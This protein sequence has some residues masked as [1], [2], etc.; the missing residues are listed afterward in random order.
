M[1]WNRKLPALISAPWPAGSF[2]RV[3]GTMPGEHVVEREGVKATDRVEQHD[4]NGI[5]RTKSD[6]FL[7]H[8]NSSLECGQD[9]GSLHVFVDGIVAQREHGL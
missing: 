8:L 4:A 5:V 3:C 6:L 2:F 9:M 7:L 1:G